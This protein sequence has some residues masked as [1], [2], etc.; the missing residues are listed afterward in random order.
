MLRQPQLKRFQQITINLRGYSR[1]DRNKQCLMRSTDITDK[2]D[3]SLIAL[4]PRFTSYNPKT[5]E[6]ENAA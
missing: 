1:A 5:Q 3:A 2:H 6:S 4:I